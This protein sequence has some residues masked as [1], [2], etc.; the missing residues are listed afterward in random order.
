MTAA[1]F[2]KSPEI[3]QL[4]KMGHVSSCYYSLHLF[5]NAQ[6]FYIIA[7]YLNP[8]LKKKNESRL[9]MIPSSS[10]SSNTVIISLSRK[11]GMTRWCQLP[12]TFNYIV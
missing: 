11:I 9:H 3:V 5:D 10:S 8:F 4:R 2:S 1:N 12:N 6:A 7:V